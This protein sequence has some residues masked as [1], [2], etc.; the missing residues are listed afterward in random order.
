M[1]GFQASM[2]NYLL[3]KEEKEVIRQIQSTDSMTILSLESDGVA[4]ISLV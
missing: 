4:D 1:V 2:Q 3:H